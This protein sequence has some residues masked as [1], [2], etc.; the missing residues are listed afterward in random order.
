MVD[1]YKVPLLLE[2]Q[3]EGG[4]TVTGPL[5]PELVTEG[6][7]SDE[8]L[9]H[10]K[11]ALAAV[12]EICEDLGR[13]LPAGLRHEADDGAISFN[14]LLSSVRPEQPS[15]LPAVPHSLGDTF[16]P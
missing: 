3:P 4:Y 2:P 12:V 1:L 11:D 5:L 7:T 15:L 14:C 6:T 13:P 16:L 10:V 9:Q 8:A